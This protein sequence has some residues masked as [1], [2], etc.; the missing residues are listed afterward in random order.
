MKLEKLVL[1]SFMLAIMNYQLQGTLRRAVASTD[2]T[3]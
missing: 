1:Q 2:L 3:T